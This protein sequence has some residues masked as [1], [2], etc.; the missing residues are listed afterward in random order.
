MHALPRHVRLL[1]PF[2][3]AATLGC[4]AEAGDCNRNC[5]SG[6]VAR[7]VDDRCECVCDELACIRECTT[8]TEL[9][10]GECDETGA[11]RCT[12]CAFGRCDDD[13]WGPD[14]RDARDVSDDDDVGTDE[15]S[16]AADDVPSEVDDVLPP[17]DFSDAAADDA[18]GPGEACAS[19]A[20]P[21]CPPGFLCVQTAPPYC[22]SDY[23]GICEPKITD[24]TGE[25]DAPICDCDGVSHRNECEARR[26]AVGTILSPCA[27]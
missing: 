17:S 24:C 19:A 14:R 15:A 20:S 16:D 26:A 1:L 18:L 25:P 4:G 10:G 5:A 9:T 13:G 21:G 2:A 3:L 22:S 23:L 7:L 11:C 27:G 12:G 8:H 6:T